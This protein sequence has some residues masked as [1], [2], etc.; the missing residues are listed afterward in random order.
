MRLFAAYPARI[1]SFHF[2]F[3]LEGPP[4]P[5]LRLGRAAFLLIVGE[6]TRRR[7]QI[8]TGP[9]TEI[10]YKLMGYGIPS[11]VLP[12]TETGDVKAKESA[13][14]TKLRRFKESIDGLRWDRCQHRS[15]LPGPVTGPAVPAVVECPLSNDVV[16]RNGRSTMCHP[17]NVMFR[18]LLETYYEQHRTAGTK[19]EKTH[20]T[21]RIVDEVLVERKGRFLVWEGRNRHSHGADGAVVSRI[22]DTG[23]KGWWTHLD[24][25]NAIR[26]KVAIS[27][28]DERKRVLA[29]RNQ[30]R[31]ASSTVRFLPGPMHPGCLG[32]AG[33][34][35]DAG[36]KRKRGEA[37]DH[38]PAGS[39]EAAGGGEEE[40][41]EPVGMLCSLGGIFA[42]A[43][44]DAVKE[45][46]QQ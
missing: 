3:R 6:S 10:L 21:W 39:E 19:E 45:S 27:L 14:W 35:R 7:Q 30:Q 13:D 31:T 38:L 16:F 1:S 15:H 44:R 5:L 25:R 40:G 33:S 20:I 23:V 28:R 22:D 2:C 43:R 11:D 42:P 41:G 12:L 26:A 18:G 24:D 46:W 9:G 4:T 29:I 37:S 17:G 36:S 34:R 8:H 32:P